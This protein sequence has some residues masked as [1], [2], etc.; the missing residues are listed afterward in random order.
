VTATPARLDLNNT[1]QNDTNLWVNFP[2]HAAYTGQNDFFPLDKKAISFRRMLLSQ[3]GSAQETED[4]LLRFFVTVAYLNVY[5]NAA[6]EENYSMLIH[7]SGKKQDHESDRA[8]IE[9]LFQGLA[10]SDTSEFDELVVRTHKAA[11]KLYP[12]ADADKLTGYV[13]ENASKATLVVLNSERDRKAAGENPTEPTSPFTV[14]VGGNIVSRGVTFPNLLSMFFTRDVRSRLQQDTYIQ[15]ARMFGARGKYLKHFELAI[16]PQL[17]AD[18][19]TCFVLHK[20]A[21]ATIKGKLGSPVWIGDSRV[22]VAADSSIDKGTV[23]LDKG[24]M[25]FGMFDY[26]SDLDTIVLEGQKSIE[27]LKKLGD[28]I[29]KDA[30]PE[31]VLEYVKAMSANA[32]DP[33]AIHTATPIAGQI[34]ADQATISRRKGF[35]GNPQLEPNKFP[36]AVYHFKI[37]YNGAGKARLYLKFKSVQ[38]IENQA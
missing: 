30:L 32:E 8:V 2:S 37:F 24:E 34:T 11:E 6:N 10:A 29:G 31:F 16:P 21:L 1:F 25:S 13:V 35:L 26:S 38:F 15:R 4:A 27:T 5:E 36:K 7:K 18:W 12:G 19:H 9:K 28:R 22:S 33:I 14:I 17:Y 20:L 23:A 3:G